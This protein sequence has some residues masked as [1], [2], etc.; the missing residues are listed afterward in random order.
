MVGEWDVVAVRCSSNVRQTARRHHLRDRS[1][2]KVSGHWGARLGA[3]HAV[4]LC[5][6]MG[7]TTILTTIRFVHRNPPKCTNPYF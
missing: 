1:A 5:L 4:S 2:V 6:A 7:L 3:D